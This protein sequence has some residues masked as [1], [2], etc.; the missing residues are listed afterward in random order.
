[1]FDVCV[2]MLYPVR[3]AAYLFNVAGDMIH[4]IPAREGDVL[5]VRPSG[6]VP[7]AVVRVLKGQWRVVHVG[8][9]NYGAL[10]GPLCDG[11][12]IPQ[13]PADALFWAA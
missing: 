6:A 11:L 3:A 12:L 4:P 2:S 5:V 9:P 10:L 7:I 1:M 8:P 13:T